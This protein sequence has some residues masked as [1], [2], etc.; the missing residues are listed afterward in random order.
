MPE[1]ASG[2]IHFTGLGNGT[3]FDTMIT[4]LK[5]LE[6]MPA[7]KMLKWKNDWNIRLQAFGEVREK[8]ASF[9]SFLSTMNTEES[10]LVK[11]AVSS[12]SSV[13]SIV[14]GSKAIEGTYNIEVNQLAS[15]S[16]AT[17]DTGLADKF[18]SINTGST[19][20]SFTYTYKG[21]EHTV[22]VEPGTNL[23]GLKNLIN[24]ANTGVRA[25]LITGAN[26]VVMQLHSMELGAQTT[27]NIDP[28]SFGGTNWIASQGQNAQVKVNGWPANTWLETS[29]NTLTDVIE[30]CSVNLYSLG[31]TSVTVSIDK[32][33]I[34]ENV[35]QFVD[36][37]NEVRFLLQQKT[38]VDEN[39]NVFLPEDSQNQY[40]AQKG[41]VLTGN[42]GIQLITSKL[43]TSLMD[44]AKGFE[45]EGKDPLGFISGDAISSLAH[46]GIVTDA[47]SASSTFGMLIFNT[48]SSL[49]VFT[50]VLD[51]NP[52]AVAEFFSSNA[53][54]S[55]DSK[56]FGVESTMAGFTKAGEYK[57]S[58]EVDSGG[59]ITSATINGKAA[60]VLSGNRL[61][62][63]KF[64]AGGPNDAD[65]ITLNVYN[66][67]PGVHPAQSHTAISQKAVADETQPINASGSNKT[68]AYTYGGNT[69]SH[70]VDGVMTLEGLRDAINAD[71]SGVAARL[72]SDSSGKMHLEM[73]GSGGSQ[74]SFA[75]SSDLD[76]FKPSDLQTIPQGDSTVRVKEGKL[77]SLKTMIDQDFLDRDEGPTD[78]RKGTLT[79]LENEYKEIMKNID[80]KIVREDE[81]VKNWERTTRLRF[82]RLEAV[83]KRYDSL[84]SQIESQ[85]KQLGSG[86][87]K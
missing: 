47:D 17:L 14:P 9:S 45:Y 51:K 68:F 65:G 30:G 69:Y 60:T 43:K 61:F 71:G 38:K 48:K 15:S 58:Y 41:G 7:Q 4:Q 79:I 83:L 23:E 18:Q 29:S 74:I 11:N 39:K 21:T 62:L 80:K 1:Y 24:N 55:T 77:T 76:G 34:K 56:D 22:R 31:K 54:A 44:K 75:P 12:N 28:A 36:K 26:G 73:S 67:T 40:E 84:S 81:R 57:V 37:M 32:E 70:T 66:L 33:K 6:L 63:D 50:D 3:D 49:P 82:A 35:V 27:L 5:K 25:S 10:F 64:G 13:A 86:S 2:S 16:Q 42:Y 8:L 87:S 59:N 52:Q 72:V 85:V 53:K 20:A 78:T 46:L 19:T